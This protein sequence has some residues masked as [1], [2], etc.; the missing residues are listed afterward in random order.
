V[1][2][3]LL[4]ILDKPESL[5]TTVPDRLGHDRRY[6]VDCSR[7]EAELGW[8]TEIRFEEGLRATIGWYQQNRGWVERAR[9]GEY[10][11]YYERVYGRSA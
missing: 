6:A 3:W 11:E 9:S 5:L 1:L 2:E 4:R 10:R 7:I 8:R